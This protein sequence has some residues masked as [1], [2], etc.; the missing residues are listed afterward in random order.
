MRKLKSLLRS[1]KFKRCL[2]I[3]GI[4]LAVFVVIN[5]AIFL[6]YKN[7]TYPNTKISNFSTG[8]TNKSGLVAKVPN[9]KVLPEKLTF[10]YQD[11]KVELTSAESGLKVNVSATADEALTKRS[12]LPVANFFLRHQTAAQ[13]DTDKTTYDAASIQLAG[14]FSKGVSDAHVQLTNGAFSIVKES[15]GYQLNKAKLQ[16]AIQATLD[17]HQTAVSVPV[18]IEPPKVKEADLTTNLKDLQDRQKDSVTYHFQSKSHKLTDAEI[19]SMHEISGTS[20]VMSDAKIRA[21]LLQVGNSFGIGVKNIAE[22]ARATKASVEQKR[23]LD[24]TFQ[25]APRKTYTYCTALKGVDASEMPELESKLA[26]TYADSRGWSLG[27]KVSFV[28]VTSGC[29]LTVWLAR[30]DLLPSFSVATCSPDWS[31]TVSPN[32]IINYDRWKGA[33]DAWNQSGGNLS[34]YRSMVINHETG[35]WLGFDHR[36]CG[37]AGQL[38][39]VMQQQSINLEGC[40]FNPWPT[41]PE[42]SALQQKLGL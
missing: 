7:R 3:T 12:W 23:A 42:L 27:G 33:S 13:I 14:T 1:Q 38:A 4:A 22:A 5:L 25:E 39:P 32:V 21:V 18:T 8:S 24:F 17:N 28:K 9:L 11:K 2:K 10:E 31:C 37:G 30:A 29:S 34:D 20:Y 15:D 26:S 35:H 36:H 41:S 16:Q 40:K 19:A 6:V